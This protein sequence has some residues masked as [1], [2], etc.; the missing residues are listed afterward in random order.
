M[1]MHLEGGRRIIPEIYH[2]PRS[3]IVLL[4]QSDLPDRSSVN[5]DAGRYVADSRTFEVHH[6]TTGGLQYEGVVLGDTPIGLD[7][8]LS[9]R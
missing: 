3:R 5:L 8:D 9:F 4:P 2:K 6:Q 1:A 7:Y